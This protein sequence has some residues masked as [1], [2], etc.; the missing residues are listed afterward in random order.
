VEFGYQTSGERGELISKFVKREVP[1][2]LGVG[3]QV[4][5]GGHISGSKGKELA[6]AKL[7]VQN[8]RIERVGSDS[9]QNTRSLNTR[10]AFGISMWAQPMVTWSKL[11]PNDSV[12]R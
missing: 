5:V 9:H 2:H 3:P 1:N 8:S 6:C 12:C 7:L 11:T 4:I 10:S